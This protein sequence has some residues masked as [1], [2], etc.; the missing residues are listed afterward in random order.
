MTLISTR[1]DSLLGGVQHIHRFKNGYGAS[2][3]RNQYSYG[4]S[5]GK[6][7]LAVIKFDGDEWDLV[8]NTHITDDTLGWLDDDDVIKLLVE[9]S[10]LSDP[11]LDYPYS[12]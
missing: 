2:V 8:Y 10:R 9:I 3:I 11:L 7:E 5:S 12:E 1:R 4:G 6:W